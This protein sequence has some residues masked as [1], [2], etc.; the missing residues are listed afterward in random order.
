MNSYALSLMTVVFFCACAHQFIRTVTAPVP[1][2]NNT[3][4]TKSALRVAKA[5]KALAWGVMT[6]AFL[7]GLVISFYQVFTEI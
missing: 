3:E 7:L 1:I 4:Y 6:G 2:F 5:Y